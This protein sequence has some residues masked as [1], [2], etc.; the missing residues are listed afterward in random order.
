MTILTK[1]F[2]ERQIGTIMRALKVSGQMIKWL[3]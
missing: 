1:S 2:E 3:N